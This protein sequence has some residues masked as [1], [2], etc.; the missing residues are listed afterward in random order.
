[1]ANANDKEVTGKKPE[2][3]AAT[4][5]VTQP[6]EST[7]RRRVWDDQI[8]RVKV[9]IWRH[10]Q[11]KNRVRYTTGVYRSYKSDDGDWHNV[12]FFDEA[13]LDDVIALAKAAKDQIARLKGIGS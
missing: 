5:A 2:G 7:E 3:T 8:N 4:D 11:P 6:N 1:M 12:H 13:D 9:A 10:P